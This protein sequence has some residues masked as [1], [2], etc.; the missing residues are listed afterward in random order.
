MRYTKTLVAVVCLLSFSVASCSYPLA[1]KILLPTG[2]KSE[3]QQ[4]RDVLVCKDR[5][6][7]EMNKTDFRTLMGAA[8]IGLTVV[9]L[10]YS[11]AQDRAEERKIFAKC[12]T[13]FGYTVLPVDDDAPTGASAPAG[14]GSSAGDEAAKLEKLNSL[15]DRGLIT[16]QE[17][18][19]KKKEILNR[20]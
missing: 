3:D 19:A 6:H 2:S 11:I 7:K 1:G 8:F 13:E 17:Y 12:M 4:L 20:M 10:P 9:G 16:Q 5:V 18:N 14:S 15:R